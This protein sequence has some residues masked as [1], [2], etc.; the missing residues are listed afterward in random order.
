MKPIA[1]RIICRDGVSLS[2]QADE[3]KYCTP[4]DDFGPY[5]EK[6][7]GF[8]EDAAGKPLAPPKEWE[9]YA[10]GDFP[11]AVYGYVPVS[12]IEEFIADHGGKNE[13]D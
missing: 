1:K 2:V 10:D 4:R 13:A 5:I 11:S 3:Y 7:V 8:I 6:E 12:L 9:Q